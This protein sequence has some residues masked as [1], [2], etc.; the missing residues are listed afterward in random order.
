MV[1]FKRES[2][3]TS[4]TAQ[5]ASLAPPSNKRQRSCSASTTP[6]DAQ[7]ASLAPPSNKR[8]RSR[9]GSRAPSS[10]RAPSAT[11]VDGPSSALPSAEPH[12]SGSVKN[13][14]LPK[15]T[16]ITVWRRSFIPTLIQFVARQ[17]NVWAVPTLQLVPVIQ[18]IW[19]VLFNIPQEI[20]ASSPIYRLVSAVLYII[21]LIR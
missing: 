21:R 13:S 15:G 5:A 7:A 18:V 10:S 2:T 14:D 6:T 20:T 3:T 12:V 4:L 16:D 17:E 9:S 1:A 19:D 8:Q 11:P